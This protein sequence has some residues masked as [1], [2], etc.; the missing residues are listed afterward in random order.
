MQQIQ[1]ASP[2]GKVKLTVLPNAERLTC[3]VTLGD[4]TVIEPS[5][6]AMNLDGFD[7]SSGVVFSNAG[8]YEISETYKASFVRDAENDDSVTV[9][10]ATSKRSDSLSI[11]LRAGGGFVGRFNQD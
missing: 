1:V 6:L 11:K 4:T 7:L 8:R 5:P 9:E 3:T 2:D 10:N